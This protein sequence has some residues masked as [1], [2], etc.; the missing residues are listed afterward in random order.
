MN[1]NSTEKL[2]NKIK[3]MIKE[4]KKSTET[5]KTVNEL[6]NKFIETSD[7]EFPKKCSN[8]DDV[9]D[10]LANSYYHTIEYGSVKLLQDYFNDDAYWFPFYYSY[11]IGYVEIYLIDLKKDCVHK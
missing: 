1:K 8:G 6:L 9:I 2:V 7:L 10:C 5:K 11:A 3:T 4:S